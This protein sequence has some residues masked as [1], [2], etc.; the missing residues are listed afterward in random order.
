MKQFFHLLY[1]LPLISFGQVEQGSNIH[2]VV[3][4]LKNQ[5]L[6]ISQDFLVRLD[7]TT[8]SKIG[9]QKILKPRNFD[10]HPLIKK[11]N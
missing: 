4:S 7:A 11:I 9:V 8:L 10:F 2:L 5:L 1:V 6:Y 3:D